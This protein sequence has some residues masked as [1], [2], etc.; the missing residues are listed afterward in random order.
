MASMKSV[1]F[2]HGFMPIT[3]CTQLPKVRGRPQ[4]PPANSADGRVVMGE[5]QDLKDLEKIKPPSIQVF[6]LEGGSAAL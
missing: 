1:I 6:H 3:Y 4:V 5:Q 2:G